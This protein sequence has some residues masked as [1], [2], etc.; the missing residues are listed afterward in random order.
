MQVIAKIFSTQVKVT[1]SD[2]WFV[3]ILG[4]NIALQYILTIATH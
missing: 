1:E 3:M 2:I 4:D